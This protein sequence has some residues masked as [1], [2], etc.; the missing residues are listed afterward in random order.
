MKIYA[1]KLVTTKITIHNKKNKKINKNKRTY[2]CPLQRKINDLNLMKRQPIFP[3]ENLQRW[4]LNVPVCN[5]PSAVG[6]GNHHG[7]RVPDVCG[8]RAGQVKCDLESAPGV[9]PELLHE[10]HQGDTENCKLISPN[11]TYC[12]W[13]CGLGGSRWQAVLNKPSR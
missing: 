6:P 2:K 11:Q 3:D 8:I 4:L 5:Y 7:I 10:C 9:F 1:Q 13:D 12:I